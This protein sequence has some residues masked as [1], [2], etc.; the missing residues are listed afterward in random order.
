MIV[1]LDREDIISLMKG[2]EP[3]YNIM[4]KIPE[5]LGRYVGGFADRWEW[6]MIIPT[7][8]SDEELYNIY[9]MCK[10]SY[11]NKK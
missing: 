11:S 1:E 7:Q 3:N 9:L 8:Y 5:D 6:D 10:E 4:H 2:T